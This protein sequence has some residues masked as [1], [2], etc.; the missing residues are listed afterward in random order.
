MMFALNTFIVMCLIAIVFYTIK[1][2]VTIKHV[3]GLY[4]WRCGRVGGSFYLAKAKPR[5]K[6][7]HREPL[8][9]FSK[10]ALISHKVAGFGVDPIPVDHAMVALRRRMLFALR[11]P[12]LAYAI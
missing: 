8:L 4:H 7:T 11:S 12:R 9:R 6:P 10:R 5:A 2:F 3:G 1:P